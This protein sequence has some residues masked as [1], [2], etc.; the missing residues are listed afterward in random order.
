M[1]TTIIEP[2]GANDST[3][4]L[5]ATEKQTLIYA[6]GESTYIAAQAVPRGGAAWPTSAVVTLELSID[7]RNYVAVPAGA[8]TYTAIGVGSGQVDVRGILFA[9]F[10]IS[11]VSASATYIGFTVSA[12]N[13]N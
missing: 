13:E 12:V 5:L 7:G 10:R 8:V 11:T 1:R 6:L 4:E 2:I 3:P 9:R